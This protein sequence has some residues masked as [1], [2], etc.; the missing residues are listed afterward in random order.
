MCICD[1]VYWTAIPFDG[2]THR[3]SPH[4]TA[5]ICTHICH[6][7]RLRFFFSWQSHLSGNDFG[8]PPLTAIVAKQYIWKANK[9]KRCGTI[10]ICGTTRRI[11]CTIRS[12][13]LCSIPQL[14]HDFQF[15]WGVILDSL[16]QVPTVLFSFVWARI[17]KVHKF[18]LFP[19]PHPLRIRWTRSLWCN[20]QP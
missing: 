11:Q 7:A 12:I 9:Q 20:T 3:S 18:R 10:G 13:I 15:E 16:F 5:S 2:L 19:H 14:F 1:L 6:C 8:W 4:L 17:L